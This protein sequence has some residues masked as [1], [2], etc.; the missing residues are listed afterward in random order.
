MD[1]RPRST[2]WRGPL[3]KPSDALL[4][5]ALLYGF[6]DGFDAIYVDIY[7]VD[8]VDEYLAQ[9]MDLGWAAIDFSDY[10]GYYYTDPT[11]EY[12][13]NVSYEE[14]ADRTVISFSS[15]MGSYV[16]EWPS[17]RIEEALVSSGW[18]ASDNSDYTCRADTP[19][20]MYYYNLTLH[21]DFDDTGVKIE[22]LYERVWLD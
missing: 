20:G 10:Y 3:P 12:Y 14:E 2:A 22:L 19:T 7:G 16:H 9:L 17:Q 18:T 15:N 5:G 21:I 1:I 11:G 4:E 13:L 6:S 8:I